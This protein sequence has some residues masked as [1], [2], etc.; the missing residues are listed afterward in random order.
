MKVTDVL[1][2]ATDRDPPGALAQSRSV[3]EAVLRTSGGRCVILTPT[4]KVA[5]RA[6]DEV[7]V[8]DAVP[9]DAYAPGLMAPLV[10]SVIE[11]VHP[12][13]VL[14]AHS[15]TNRDFAAEVAYTQ[16]GSILTNCTSVVLDGD[17]LLATRMIEGGLVEAEFE[18]RATP[19][20]IT[21][22]SQTAGTA[23]SGPAR[24]RRVR[25]TAFPE[26]DRRVAVVR[27][28]RDEDD[29]GV[30]LANARIVVAGG[31]GVGDPRNW[32]L[33]EALARSLRGAVG[34]TRAATDAGWAPASVQIGLTGKTVA[35]EVYFAVGVSGATQHLA[36]ITGAKIVVA[37][38]KDPEA[39]IF[40]R[41]DIGVVD[42]CLEVLPA[43]M[44]RLD[45]LRSGASAG[46]E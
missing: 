8:Y 38:N 27:R 32:R 25:P 2:V 1:V 36:G 37:I 13:A 7:L 39:D 10:A 40:K 9:E 26:R 46:R 22:A 19:C 20:I 42:D 33:V 44:E 17:I 24:P 31:R 21:L 43:L 41:A 23:E 5:V 12:L 3:A 4:A 30:S 6:D 18:M 15:A 14:L 16:R 28:E 45:E 29:A 11:E 34:A 35:P